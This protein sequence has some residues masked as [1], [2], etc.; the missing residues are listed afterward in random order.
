[1]TGEPRLH[2]PSGIFWAPFQ[3]YNSHMYSC[4]ISWLNKNE[5]NALLNL[6]SRQH[7]T[8]NCGLRFSMKD[9][10]LKV[11]IICNNLFK[12]KESYT[13]P[14]LQAHP[15]LSGEH[16][17][18][19]DKRESVRGMMETSIECEQGVMGWVRFSPHFP[20]QLVCPRFP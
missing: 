14:P 7:E 12:N 2:K 6:K 18:A 16:T 8:A 4:I 17:R 20:Y 10:M 13:L 1:M 3:P 15:R 11:S 9:L 5:L 19:G